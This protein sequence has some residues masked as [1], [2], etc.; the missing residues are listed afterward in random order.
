MAT[1][2]QRAPRGMASRITASA[3]TAFLAGDPLALS[4]ALRLPP[5]QV[6]PLDAAGE[7][8]YPAGAAGARTWADSVE[9]REQ[10]EAAS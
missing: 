6:S 5:W 10:L 1:K 2:R 9:L 3:A 8:P 4:H 7:C